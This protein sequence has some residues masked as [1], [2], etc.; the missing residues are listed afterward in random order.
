MSRDREFH[1][2]RFLVAGSLAIAA[3]AA[4]ETV[5]S[6]DQVPGHLKTPEAREVFKQ[7]IEGKPPPDLLGQHLPAALSADVLVKLL[8]PITETA[9]PTLIGA[10]PWPVEPDFYVAIVC[11][12][13]DGPLGG[14]TQCAQA[15][16]TKNAPLHVYLALIAAKT[17]AAPVLVAASAPVAG[18]MNWRKTML[19]RAPAAADDSASGVL[20][21]EKFDALDLAPYRIAPGQPAFGLRGSWMEGYSGGGADF[22]GL[23]LFARDGKRLRQVLALP[24][25]AS[26]NIAG[27]WHKDGTRDHDITDAANVLIVSNHL[28]DGHFDLIVKAREGRGRQTLRWSKASGAYTP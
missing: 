23:C 24:M 9:K 15:T 28:T 10:R 5:H 26:V 20:A 17:G 21:P 13:G 22:G 6:L 25:S 2:T 3:P 4:A 18:A 19:P 8:V 7:E 11:T 16:D 12:G 27:D 1:F 14:E